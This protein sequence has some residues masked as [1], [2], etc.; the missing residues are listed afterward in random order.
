[1]AN[2]TSFN[3]SDAALY[4]QAI[5]LIG[6]TPMDRTTAE[7]EVRRRLVTF[8]ERRRAVFS[9]PPLRGEMTTLGEKVLLELRQ[10]GLVSSVDDHVSLTAAGQAIAEKLR[11]GRGRDARLA[12]AARMIESF[13]NVGSLCTG[14]T[15]PQGRPLYLPLARAIAEEVVDEEEGEARVAPDDLTLVC[16]S[17]REWCRVEKRPD[18]LPADFEQ[19]TKELIEASRDKGGFASKARN[20][21]AQLVLDAATR[22]VVARPAVF[23]TIRDRLSSVG[24]I[25]SVIREIVG[26][27]LAVEVVF[28]CLHLGKP[29]QNSREWQPIPA[30]LAGQEVWIHESEPEV[31]ADV[32]LASMRAAMKTLTERAGYYRIYEVRD[33]VCESLRLS[34]GM[35][36]SVFTYLYR[37]R[38]G[39]MTLGVDY[40]K[41]TAKR[42]PIEVRDGNTSSLFNLVALKE[43]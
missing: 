5:A 30:K 8:L 35:F 18:L 31:L 39:L 37:N 43:S 2:I 32:V 19:R 34:Q 16:E 6:S 27:P 23:R 29:P 26:K 28:S 38:P 41:I 20:A 4:Y 14:L 7:E 40:E 36:D 33:R 12:V 11:G 17:W 24:A 21:M 15:P 10:M 25:N 3:V 42:L 1:M 22:G 9:L 13:D